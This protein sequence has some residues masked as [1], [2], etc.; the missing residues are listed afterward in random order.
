MQNLDT[1]CSYAGLEDIPGKS[2]RQKNEIHLFKILENVLDRK[3]V[4]AGSDLDFRVPRNLTRRPGEDQIR[5]IWTFTK[6]YRLTISRLV[7]SMS[8]VGGPS[9]IA[10]YIWPYMGHIWPYGGSLD[11]TWYVLTCLVTSHP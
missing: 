10:Y 5:V 4:L 11:T 8:M 2:R 1:D 7:C 6:T 3:F 9:R